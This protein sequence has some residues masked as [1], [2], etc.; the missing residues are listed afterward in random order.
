MLSGVQ[1]LRELFG[2]RRRAFYAQARV[3]KG[4][5][6]GVQDAAPGAVPGVWPQW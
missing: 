2:D 5:R 4:G 1:E 6:C 3:G